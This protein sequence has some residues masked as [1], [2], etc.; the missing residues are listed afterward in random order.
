MMK[1]FRK[2]A[3]IGGLVMAQAAVAAG[4]PVAHVFKGGD[5][6]SASQVNANF[7]EL[8]DRIAAIPASLV[9]DYRNFGR[10]PAITQKTFA[11][12]GVGCGGGMAVTEVHAWTAG[13]AAGQVTLTRTRND[14]TADC[15]KD[16]FVF[17]T[18]GPQM[19]LLRRERVNLAMGTVF[20]T[21]TMNP[22]M[23]VRTATMG[24]GLVT[25]SAGAIDID[26]ASG[27]ATGDGYVNTFAAVGLE[28][29]NLTVNGN[30]VIYTG[31]LRLHEVR[32]SS[33]MGVFDR[34]SWYCPGVGLAKRVSM[35]P[36]GGQTYATWTLTGTQ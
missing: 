33:K 20:Q 28:D 36:A 18:G 35:D 15:L 7:Q 17:N 19:L 10:D 27:Q 26:G 3:V 8:A 34:I 6:A 29:L 22:P 5:P 16:N 9:Y 14:G 32:T 30:A 1:L 23:V 11:V 21:R 24:R 2:L 25:S 4:A 31:C 13:P 12:T